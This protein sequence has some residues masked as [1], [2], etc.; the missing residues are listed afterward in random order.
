MKPVFLFGNTVD[1]Y[2]FVSIHRLVTTFQHVHVNQ[3]SNRGEDH[4]RFLG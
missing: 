2:G 3:M 1:S 4:V